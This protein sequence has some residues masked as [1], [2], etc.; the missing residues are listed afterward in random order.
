MK[1]QGY[2][3]SIATLLMMLATGYGC[4]NNFESNNRAPS[5]LP[6]EAIQTQSKPEN[7]AKHVPVTWSSQKLRYEVNSVPFVGKDSVLRVIKDP[8]THKV[9]RTFTLGTKMYQNSEGE[10]VAECLENGIFLENGRKILVK[11]NKRFFIEGIINGSVFVS[12]YL[13]AEP[14][15]CRAMITR[16]EIQKDRLVRLDT[17]S[18]YSHEGGP[19]PAWRFKKSGGFLSGEV[20]AAFTESGDSIIAIENVFD[21][22]TSKYSNHL[23]IY[24]CNFP[25]KLS[26]V[27]I[28]SKGWV[29]GMVVAQDHILTCANTYR[30]SRTHLSWFNLQGELIWQKTVGGGFRDRGSSVGFWGV[31]PI[32]DNQQLGVC[33]ALRKVQS[34]E[35]GTGAENWSINLSDVLLPGEK[36]IDECTIRSALNFFTLNDRYLVLVVRDWDGK[37]V[38]DSHKRDFILMLNTDGEVVNTVPLIDAD[39]ANYTYQIRGSENRFELM[40]P[41]RTI[42]VE[43]YP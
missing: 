23:T 30:P 41:K 29:L 43:I 2:F 16:N 31:Q 36:E 5:R 24:D 22:A 9:Y 7:S 3:Y 4:T 27:P 15:G 12:T 11:E 38:A 1:Y 34:W 10:T 33:I 37:P 20:P 17:S 39:P 25:K 40:T 6:K 28:N 14:S 13:Y 26:S 42:E 18:F 32:S 35:A 8:V 19:G 21:S